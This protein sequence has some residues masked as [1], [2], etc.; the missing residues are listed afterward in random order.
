MLLRAYPCRSSLVRQAVRLVALL[1]FHARAHL[2]SCLY[3]CAVIDVKHALAEVLA[4]VD[5]QW[6]SADRLAAKQT[7][8]ISEAL[9]RTKCEAGMRVV[10]LP[11]VTAQ[12]AV[13]GAGMK[14]N[15]AR[16]RR[17]GKAGEIE[18]VAEPKMAGADPVCRVHFEEL[19][20]EGANARVDS[21]FLTFPIGALGDRGATR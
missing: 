21:V 10:V 7:A 3:C 5:A 1:P 13:E 6:E 12:A 8:S 19:S 18:S 15:A 4:V 9:T 2:L 17:I 20:G 16:K 14:W 11:L